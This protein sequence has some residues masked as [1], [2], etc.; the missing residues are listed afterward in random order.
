MR[1]PGYLSLLG[2][3]L[4]LIE[5]PGEIDVG[6]RSIGRRRFRSSV[7]L[8]RDERMRD[9]SVRMD[10]GSPDAMKQRWKDRQPP[11]NE[12]PLTDRAGSS[13]DT[14]AGMPAEHQKKKRMRHKAYKSK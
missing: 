6:E 10:P 7:C 5:P 14:L 11:H 1:L 4:F 8:P 13:A 9:D 12:M 2:P 3:S